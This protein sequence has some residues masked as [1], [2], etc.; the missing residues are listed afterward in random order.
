MDAMTVAIDLAKHVFE[1]AV[2]GREGAVRQRRR[3]SRKQFSAF[4]D[5]LDARST[6]VMEACGTAHYWARR[7]QARG[8]TVR[9]LPAQYVRAYVRRNKTDRTDTEALLDADRCRGIHSVPVKSAD[10]QTLQGLHRVRQQGQRTR[11]ARINL[12]RALLREQGIDVPAGAYLVHRRIAALL[13]DETVGVPPAL[14]ELIAVPSQPAL[15]ELARP[16]PPRVLEWPA[17]HAR[18]DQHTGRSLSA[19]VA[20][21]RRPVRLARGG[22]RRPPGPLDALAA[23]GARHARP[24]RSQSRRRRPGT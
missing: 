4:I 13:R 7:C 5:T 3:F 8:A 6:V 9:L 22:T 16:A 17:P 2:A 12:A 10:Q 23:M 11:T 15:C 19:H 18:G 1:V 14:R 21:S 24:P 20:D